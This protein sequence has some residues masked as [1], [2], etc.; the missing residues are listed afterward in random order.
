MGPFIYFYLLFQRRNSI[1]GCFK[2]DF[3]KFKFF[4][5]IRP[6]QQTPRRPVPEHI[7]LP[8]YALHPEGVSL[9]EKN[10]RSTGHI[11]VCFYYLFQLGKAENCVL[12]F[13]ISLFLLHFLE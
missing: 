3:L 1:F 5:Y 9:G 12:H 11:L 13:R 10:S 4:L 8:D 7:V 2:L 6:A